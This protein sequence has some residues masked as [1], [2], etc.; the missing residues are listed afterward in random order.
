MAKRTSSNTKS[1][2]SAR[3]A[4]PHIEFIARGLWIHGSK[5]LLCRNTIKDYLYLPGGHI[6]FGESAAAA[7]AREFLEETG[8]KVRVGPMLL[9]TEGTFTTKKHRHHELN[10]MFH[11]EHRSTATTKSPPRV[12]SKEKG[13]A[14]EWLD[15]AA[16]VDSDIRPTAIKAWLATGPLTTNPE[17]VS[18][19]SVNA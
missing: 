17:W 18:E 19:I 16:V 15:L 13:I 5:V 1:P 12:I 6:E 10:L 2:K 3:S 8:I 14:F 11:V 7:L 9:A 4:K